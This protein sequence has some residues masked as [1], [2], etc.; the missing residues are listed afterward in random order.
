MMMKRACYSIG[1]RFT[2]LL[3]E[4]PKEVL[5]LGRCKSNCKT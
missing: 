3:V 1:T 5:P 4:A 2:G